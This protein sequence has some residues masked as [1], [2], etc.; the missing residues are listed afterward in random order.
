MR[1]YSKDQLIVLEEQNHDQQK[2]RS[3]ATRAIAVFWMARYWNLGASADKKVRYD[4][5]DKKWLNWAQVVIYRHLGLFTTLGAKVA[6]MAIWT[7]T[8]ILVVM[9]EDF[10]RTDLKRKSCLK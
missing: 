7:D 1:S 4:R 9:Q 6:H 3:G 5:S 8:Q 2:A 10:G